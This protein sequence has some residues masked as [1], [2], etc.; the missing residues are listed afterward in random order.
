MRFSP[1]WWFIP[2]EALSLIILCM[3]VLV[4]F[5]IVRASRLVF[6]VISL[7][8]LPV[9]GPLLEALFDLLPLWVVLS[10]LLILAISVFRGVAACFIGE[11]AADEMTGAL[12]ADVVRGTV[13]LSWRASLSVLRGLVFA[14]RGFK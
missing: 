13:R 6:P 2:I 9:I 12:A 1:V 3:G 11:R 8:M 10:V 14:A 4:L 5:R 7:L